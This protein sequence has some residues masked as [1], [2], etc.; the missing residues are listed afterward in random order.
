M[1]TNYVRQPAWRS[2]FW[3]RPGWPR[4]RPRNRASSGSRYARFVAT[5]TRQ[6]F[7]ADE[8]T[9]ARFAEMKA[10]TWIVDITPG[11]TLAY[12]VR[13][14]GEPDGFRVEFDLSKPN[15]K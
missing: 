8:E 14:N 3:P 6:E 2:S 4:S 11:R 1:F 13:R 7:P 15:L 12:T 5:H 9:G 10:L